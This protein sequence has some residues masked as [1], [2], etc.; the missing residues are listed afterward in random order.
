[1]AIK[2]GGRILVS[3][4]IKFLIFNF[5]SILNALILNSKTKKV[6]KLKN[7]KFGF[8]LKFKI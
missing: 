8:D 3:L 5:N 1:M 4:D 6:L 2:R 7:L